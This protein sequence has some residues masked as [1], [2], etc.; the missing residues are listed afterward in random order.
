MVAYPVVTVENATEVH[1]LLVR[2]M[3]H[4][5]QHARDNGPIEYGYGDYIT[6]DS[7]KTLAHTATQI[8]AALADVI[9]HP[10]EYER[11]EQH[12]PTGTVT[13]H[14]LA[15]HYKPGRRP[16]T[17]PLAA[18]FRFITGWYLVR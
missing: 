4:T 12:N 1:A 10:W 3:K 7:P 17:P 14:Y 16:K 8:N 5:L 2:D 18:A 6:Y 13:V 11:T 9:S 15:A